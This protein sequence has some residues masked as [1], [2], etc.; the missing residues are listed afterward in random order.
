MADPKVKVTFVA[1]DEITAA[2][3]GMSGKVESFGRGMLKVA[4]GMGLADGFKQIGRAIRESIGEAAEAYPKLGAGLS[5]VT[6]KFSEFRIQVGAAF[7]EAIQPALPLLEKLLGWATRLATQIPDAIDGVRITI[8]GL[9][10]WF[11]KIPSEAAEAFGG[12]VK[13]AGQAMAFLSGG[14][15]GSSMI[16]WGDKVVVNAKAD[17]KAIEAEADRVI[18]KYGGGHDYGTRAMTKEQQAAADKAR[19][20]AARAKEAAEKAF[21]ERSSKAIPT[22]PLKGPGMDIRPGNVLQEVQSNEELGLFMSSGFDAFDQFAAGLEAVLGPLEQFNE[23]GRT[24]TQILGEMAAMVS[25]NLAESYAVFFEQLGAGTAKLS[26]FGKATVKA[27]AGAA[28]SE[29]KIGMAEGFAKMAKALFPYNPPLMASGIGMVAKNAALIAVASKIG[30]IGGG[31]GGGGS[32]GGFAGSG[33][34]SSANV[35]QTGR[36]LATRGKLTVKVSGAGAYERSPEYR[37]HLT[38]ILREASDL[39]EVEIIAS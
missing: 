21:L 14:T 20:A 28:I 26:D 24:T 37:D 23:L 32:A 4:A 29:G 38:S 22:S 12:L 36:D 17:I 30:S 10:A 11:K 31:S 39:R 19:D 1:Q 5:Q 18:A 7:L 3:R 6:A 34:L 9:V 13:A 25:Q 16:A 8:A 35:M 27:V 15:V 2:L 33:S